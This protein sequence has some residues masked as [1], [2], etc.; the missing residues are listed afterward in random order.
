[1]AKP[2]QLGFG[3]DAAVK[4]PGTRHPMGAQH[5]PRAQQP[6]GL[7][8]HLQKAV[9]RQGSGSLASW[10]VYEGILAAPGPVP[11]LE[12][13]LQKELMSAGAEGWSH[14]GLKGKAAHYK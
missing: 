11:G 8:K 2:L 10:R 3:K 13:R 5:R 14:H 12:L 1:M 6:P 9:S 4:M 7:I